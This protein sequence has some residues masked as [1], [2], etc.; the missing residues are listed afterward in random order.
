M[1][2]ISNYQWHQ[3]GVLTSVNPPNHMC[4]AVASTGGWLSCSVVSAFLL[5]LAAGA[6]PRVKSTIPEVT[7]LGSGTKSAS[8]RIGC[9]WDLVHVRGMLRRAGSMFISWNISTGSNASAGRS[10][11]NNFSS[12]TT[13]SL[14]SSNPPCKE[15]Y[16]DITSPNVSPLT[17]IGNWGSSQIGLSKAH[18]LFFS[19]ATRLFHS[20]A[21]WLASH[22][23]WVPFDATVNRFGSLLL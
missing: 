8:R 12:L 1:I 21:F 17:T 11:I 6:L 23:W 3:C 14:I 4:L 10:S 19:L 2:L 20:T 18:P 22:I 7:V 13:S 5:L 16:F 15:L 9:D